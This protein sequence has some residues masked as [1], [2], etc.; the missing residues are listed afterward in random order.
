M[1]TYINL[2]NVAQGWKVQSTSAFRPHMD[3]STWI[4]PHRSHPLRLVSIWSQTMDYSSSISSCKA[5][6]HMIADDRGSQIADR[7]RSQRELFPY[8]CRRSQTIAE[9]TV[10]IQFGQRKCQ[11]YTRVVQAENCG[12]QHGGRRLWSQICAWQSVWNMWIEPFQVSKFS[13]HCISPRSR[14]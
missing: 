12:K 4:I 6:F 9:A 13:W 2:L 3:Y 7:R 1:K 10:A 5:G 14:R 11:N 8:N